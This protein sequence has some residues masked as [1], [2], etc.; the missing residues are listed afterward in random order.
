[1]KDI[2]AHLKKIR[3]DAAECLVLSGIAP[4][5]KG[6]MFTRIAEHLNALALDIEKSATAIDSNGWD[7]HKA[8]GSTGLNVAPTET[9][10]RPRRTSLRFGLLSV[11]VIAACILIGATS[12]SSSTAQYW[13]LLLPKHESQPVQDRTSSQVVT[14]VISTEQAERKVLFEE[15]KAF[16]GRLDN[17]DRKLDSLEKATTEIAKLLTTATVSPEAKG[18]ATEGIA[19]PA[20]EKSAS[21]AEN[22]TP[23]DE[24]PV[25][26]K[27]SDSVGPR[28]CT[29]FRSF[30]SKSGSYVTLDGRRRPCR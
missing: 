8:E 18:A 5:G 19:A 16:G 1:M 6:T 14:D 22:S 10:R 12:L 15:V 28:G 13:S 23:L 17:F 29:Q 4:D 3:S 30:D 21:T 27:P 20:V 2:H 26:V 9:T 25:H 24:P 11:A 7:T